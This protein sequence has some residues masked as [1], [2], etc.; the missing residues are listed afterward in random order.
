MKVSVSESVIDL[1][2]KL[3]DETPFSVEDRPSIDRIQEVH[4]IS[5]DELEGSET[6]VEIFTEIHRNG[7]AAEPLTIEFHPHRHEQGWTLRGHDVVRILQQGRL[8]E[9]EKEQYRVFGAVVG[10]LAYH[11]P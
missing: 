9:Y 5:K 6:Y 2:E 11:E 10:R 3:R 4:V 8:D 1:I 7:E